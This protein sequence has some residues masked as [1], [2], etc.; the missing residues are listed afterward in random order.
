MPFMTAPRQFLAI[1]F[2]WLL[3]SLGF[4]AGLSPW[5][6]GMTK[7]Q[8]A[9]FKQFGP[10][11]SFS[12]GDLETY[13]GVYRGQKHNVQFYFQSNRLVKIEVLFGE[14]TDRDKAIAT[15]RQIYGILEKGY[16]K[17]VVPEVHVKKGSDPVNDEVLAIAAAANASVTGYSH[18]NPLNQPRDMHVWGT[19]ASKVIGNE[20]WFYVAIMFEPL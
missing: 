16:G 20:R 3:P 4:A 12:N 6:F 9:S 11:K 13:K 15:F 19:L 7:E 18:I 14:G 8:V 17:V 5:Q 1:L 2:A 10:Y